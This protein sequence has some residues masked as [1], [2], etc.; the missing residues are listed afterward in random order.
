MELSRLFGIPPCHLRLGWLEPL[1][2]HI[3]GRAQAR[4]VPSTG[5]CRVVR[6][7]FRCRHRFID[8]TRAGRVCALRGSVLLGFESAAFCTGTLPDNI[9]PFSFFSRSC[10]AIHCYNVKLLTFG[11]LIV[12]S[13]QLFASPFHT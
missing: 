4:R 9:S 12:R 1:P 6:E 10:T 2:R 8:L 11:T 5:A 7:T 3:L 13:S